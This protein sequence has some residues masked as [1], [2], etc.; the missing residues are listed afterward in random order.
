MF[1]II[2]QD[3]RLSRFHKLTCYIIHDFHTGNSKFYFFCSRLK[4]NIVKQQ[5][6]YG[7]L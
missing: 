5:F 6:F 2:L 1:K 4:T 3:K 7:I